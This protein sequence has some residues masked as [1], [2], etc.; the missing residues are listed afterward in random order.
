MFLL[1]LS[2]KGHIKMWGWRYVLRDC[3]RNREGIPPEQ[4]GTVSANDSS[5]KDH[6]SLSQVSNGMML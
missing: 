4:D 6:I 5:T 3:K 2:K 1:T